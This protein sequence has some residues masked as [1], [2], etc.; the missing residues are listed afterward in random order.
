MTCAVAEKSTQKCPMVG[1]EAITF[2]TYFVLRIVATLFMGAAFSLLDATALSIVSR[3]GKEYG[4]QRVW[5]IIAMAILSPITGIMVDVISNAKGTQLL[6]SEQK[7]VFCR[8]T[9]ICL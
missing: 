7:C 3:E 4:K 9:K 2:W 8:R 1:N 6:L 5:A